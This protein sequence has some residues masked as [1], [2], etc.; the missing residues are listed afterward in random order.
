MK[1]TEATSFSH[2]TRSCWKGM[3]VDTASSKLV[4]R[5]ADTTQSKSIKFTPTEAELIAN[6]WDLY[7]GPK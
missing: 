4:W 5:H 3:Y 2:I 7:T 1:Y 6:D